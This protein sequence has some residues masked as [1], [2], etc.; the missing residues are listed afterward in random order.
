MEWVEN[1]LCVTQF[2]ETIVCIDEMGGGGSQGPPL[3]T[4]D[5]IYKTEQRSLGRVAYWGMGEGSF[6]GA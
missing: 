2:M 4:V 1:T 3:E 6:T 5:S